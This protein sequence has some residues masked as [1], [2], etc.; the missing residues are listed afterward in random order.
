[1]SRGRFV[2]PS[3]TAERVERVRKLITALQSGPLSRDE[4]GGLLSLSP[5]A[6]RKYM[7]DLNGVIETFGEFGHLMCRLTTDSEKLG[8]YLAKLDEQA[9]SRPV[10]P[11]KCE[12]TIAAQ[13]PARNFHIMEDDVEFKVRVTKLIPKHEPVLAAFFNLVPS[14]VWA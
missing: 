14:G 7:V 8:A 13:D 9:A 3:R 10:K 12:L 1:M 2:T 5:P 6:V 4:I 11:R